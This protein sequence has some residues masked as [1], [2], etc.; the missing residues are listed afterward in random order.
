MELRWYQSEGIAAIYDFFSRCKPGEIRNPIE[1]FPT[2]TGKSYII[3]EFFRGIFIKWPWQRVL[4]LTHVKELIGQNY[5]ELMDL[6]PMAPAG[7]Y[8]A[9]LNRR[10]IRPIT[11]AGIGSVVGKAELFGHIDLV[12]IDECH[13][14]SP[15]D[16]TMYGEFIA[17]LRKINPKVKVIGLTATPYRMGQGLLTEP[18]FTTKGVKPAL[19]TDII[20]DVSRRDDFTRLIAE[21]YLAPLIPRQTK[22]QID[23]SGIKVL[24][25]DFAQ[26]ALEAL[27]DRDEL[28]FNCIQEAILLGQDRKHWLVFATGSRHCEHVS[29]MLNRCGVPAM[30][31]HSKSG[32]RD[33]ATKKFMAGEIRAL[34]NNVI[35]STGFNYRPIDLILDLQPTA[36]ASRHVQKY[37]RGTRTAPGKTNCL[38]LDFAGNTMRNGPI[39]DPVIPRRKGQPRP[40]GG[41]GPAAKV[42]EHCLTLNHAAAR[43]CQCCSEE[44]PINGIA[45]TDSA[46]TADVIAGAVPEIVIFK[47][48]RTEYQKYTPNVHSK[49]PPSLMVTYHCGLRSFRDCVALQHGGYGSKRA[50]DWW[51]NAAGE[52]PEFQPPDSVDLALTKLETLQRPTH[53]KVWVNCPEPQVMDYDYKGTAFGTQVPNI[54]K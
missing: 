39:N 44:F 30:A 43:I 50:R 34:V 23:V 5:K 40:G 38:I 33:E 51:R 10:E 53:L 49:K 20:Y 12:L 6:W 7:I 36:S 13:T 48:D 41:G 54:L 26:G 14:V 22:T 42:C 19:F 52:G 32:N 47:V 15:N 2:G 16:D 46:S 17:D 24:G 11:Y 25:A 37:G 28:T 3:A 4:N 31:V 1:V 21:G 9:G 27:V 45:L 29:E 8:S 35:Y 18:T